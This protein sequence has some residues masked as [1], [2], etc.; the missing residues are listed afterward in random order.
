MITVEVQP[1]R[2]HSGPGS[3][4]LLGDTIYCFPS[5]GLTVACGFECSYSRHTP[6]G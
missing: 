5:M 1:A 6:Y 3:V 4:A 2:T